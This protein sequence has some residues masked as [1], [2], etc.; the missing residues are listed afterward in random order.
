MRLSEL[1]TDGTA[2]RFRLHGRVSMAN[3]LRRALLHDVP[4]WAPDRVVFRKN[5]TCQPDEY[6]AHRIG[7]IPFARVDE[8]DDT[9]LE[10]SVS[11][12]D[13]L[14]S[15]IVSNA[16]GA[17]HHQDVMSMMPGQT[18]DCSILM[19]RDCGRVHSRFCPVAGVGYEIAPT[20]DSV[21][22]QFETINGQ[23]PTGVLFAAI[24]SLVNRLDVCVK[25]CVD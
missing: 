16:F 3:A 12:R 17:V 1:Y 20:G 6:I 5:T 4:M 9:V 18:L 13:A 19:R 23:C 21:C 11:D 8:G 24:D 14:T 10:L 7:M 15:D 25:G 2:M 22:F